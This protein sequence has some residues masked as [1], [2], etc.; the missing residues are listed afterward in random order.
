MQ[1]HCCK[2]LVREMSRAS[3]WDDVFLFAVR[4]V[5]DA[6]TVSKEGVTQRRLPN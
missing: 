1:L 5:S 2:I 6:I 3:V 4:F